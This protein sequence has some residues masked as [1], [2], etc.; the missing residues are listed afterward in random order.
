MKRK[1]IAVLRA[2]ALGD[3]IFVLPALQLLRSIFPD[4]EIFYL[5]K[6]MHQVFLAH[7]PS[8]VD[9][10]VV[11]PPY[12]GV[13]EAEDFQADPAETDAFF[14]AMQAERFDIALQLHGGGKNS[15]PFLLRLG[16]AFTVGLGTPDAVALDVTIPYITY[17]NETLR[18][19]EV[20]SYL[21]MHH[22]HDSML[23]VTDQDMEEAA[24]VM[25]QPGMP[26]PSAVLHPG[27]SDL[28][29]RWPAENFARIAD[30]L[31]EEGWQVYINGI[32]NE[33]AISEEIISHM[34]CRYNVCDLSGK[35][36]VNGLTGLLSR[37]DLVISNDSGPLH[38]AHILHIP[39]VG[40][41][42]VGNM[43]TG[44]PLTSATCRPAISWTT[45]CPVCGLECARLDTVSN[46]CRHE[47][48]FVASVSVEEVRASV[49]ELMK[50]KGRRQHPAYAMQ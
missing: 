23:T 36:S 26:A 15:N 37:A 16:A 29:R 5:G 38:L 2:N 44:M 4:A 31:V 9:H 3:F 6:Q 13:G 8:P 39:A 41:Y 12:P 46:G 1:K 14:Q 19:L 27:A 43:I 33:R 7:R 28:R 18:Y 21:S 45:R 11:I 10:V 47:V 42:W 17:F 22:S 50:M 34:H 48:S 30:F 20:V 35:I 49:T 40:I 24:A 32:E 25:I